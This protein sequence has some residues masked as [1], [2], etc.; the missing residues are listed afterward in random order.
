MTGSQHTLEDASVASVTDEE[1]AVRV[2]KGDA[3]AFGGLME[4]YEAKLLRYGRK[5]LSDHDDVTDL[6]QE[7]FVRAYQHIQSFDSTQRFS[8]WM[9]RI[10]HNEFV[11]A[12]RKR[13]R[14]PL[15]IDFD[16]LVSHPAYDDPAPREREQKEMRVLIDKGLEKIT[17]KYREV[18]VLYFLEDL[19]Y[20]EIADVLKVPV[21]T[22]GIRLK[23]GKEALRQ[24]YPSHEQPYGT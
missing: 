10:A 24:V 15:T 18:L 6:V 19:S 8:P 17:S 11:S 20:K 5:F 12:L 21:S 1:L 2:Q 3:E 9:Y 22:V 13:S 14:S 4:R 16:A 7:A 23:R